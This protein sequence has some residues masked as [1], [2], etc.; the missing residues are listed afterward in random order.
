M[1]TISQYTKMGANIQHAPGHMASEGE[2]K[3]KIFVFLVEIGQKRLKII[4][5]RTK[6]GMYAKGLTSVYLLQCGD[7]RGEGFAEGGGFENFQFGTELTKFD[8]EIVGRCEVEREDRIFVISLYLLLCTMPHGCTEE[9][10]VL[11]LDLDNDMLCIRQR[12]VHAELV[13]EELGS[14]EPLGHLERFFGRDQFFHPIEGI[15]AG[16]FLFGMVAGFADEVPTVL[17][18]FEAVWRKKELVWFGSVVPLIRS[19]QLSSFFH[20]A[21]DG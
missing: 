17:E 15:Y 6:L 21:D 2:K 8:D 18:G 4:P 19:M 7:V 5:K 11:G 1:G 3:C 13:S 9:V 10:C 20:G 16:V 12:S 14:L